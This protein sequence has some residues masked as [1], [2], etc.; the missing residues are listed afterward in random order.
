MAWIPA[1]AAFWLVSCAA[2]YL[3]RAGGG[4]W[5][6]GPF[7]VLLVVHLARAVDWTR[8]A[9]TPVRPLLVVALVALLPWRTTFEQARVLQ[10]SM[11]PARSFLLAAREIAAGERILSEDY[12]FF[13]DRYQG[14]LIDMGDTVF[15]MS[16]TG[17][18]GADLTATADRY[19]AQLRANPPPFVISGGIGSPVLNELLA[20]SYKARLRLPPPNWPYVGP[21]QTFYQ[22]KPVAPAAPR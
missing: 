16:A 7:Y 10:Q 14:E 18:Y 15:K 3:N 1:L 12:Y 20:K 22:L 13:E 11:E 19:F 9:L 17:Y 2:Y 4:V 21:P 8:T 6:F 5:Y